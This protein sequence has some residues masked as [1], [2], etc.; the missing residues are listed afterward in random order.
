MVG[1]YVCPCSL[2]LGSFCREIMVN[3]YTLLTELHSERPK[4]FAVL[5]AVG[6]KETSMPLLLYLP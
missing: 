6:L 4:L 3:R 1:V 2:D 5:S